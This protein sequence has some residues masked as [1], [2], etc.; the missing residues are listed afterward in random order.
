[1]EDALCDPL[2]LPVVEVCKLIKQTVDSNMANGIATELRTRGY[3]PED[4][5]ILAYG[6]NGPLHAG[7]IARA[8]SVSRILAPPLASPFSE[9]GAGNMRQLHIHEKSARE[10][11]RHPVPNGTIV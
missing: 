10:P 7:R 3:E 5:T 8:L 2:D 9:V 4:F 1:M 6:G 11:H